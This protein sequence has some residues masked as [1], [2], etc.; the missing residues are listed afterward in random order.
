MEVFL[1]IQ[2]IPSYDWEDK[3]TV[4]SWNKK[5]LFFANVLLIV[6]NVSVE[7]VTVTIDVYGRAVSHAVRGCW[8]ETCILMV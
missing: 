6:G 1:V 3:L 5:F 8:T 4:Y 2:N 7:T